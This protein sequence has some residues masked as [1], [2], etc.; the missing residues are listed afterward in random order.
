MILKTQRTT[1]T[2][3]AA[4]LC[5]CGTGSASTFLW[6]TVN[7]TYGLL[8]GTAVF[9]VLPDANLT[10]C[11]ASSCYFLQ[12]AVTNTSTNPANQTS[13]IVNGLFFDITTSRGA[14]LNQQLGMYSAT[15]TGGQLAT[16]GTTIVAGSVGANICGSGNVG[17]KT[18]VC[19]GGSGW[20]AA[21]RDV[22][23]AAF[24]VGGTAYTQHYGLGDAGWGLFNG[25]GVGNPTNGLVPGNGV[26]ISASANNGLKNKFPYVYGSAT[27][28]L[29]GLKDPNILITNVVAD[30]GTAPEAAVGANTSA[31]P[32][33]GAIVMAAGGLVLLGALRRRRRAA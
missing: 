7:P 18:Q 8:K 33:P 20:E 11:G 13:Q 2:L 28:V 16:T 12:I 21:Y 30:Y 26:G 23:A 19:A 24:S 15:A 29:Y 14:N 27:F 5:M 1:L 17:A 31:A 10:D 25:G 32:E 6:S 9:T 3:I 22:N 4:A